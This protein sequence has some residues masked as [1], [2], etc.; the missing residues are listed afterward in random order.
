MSLTEKVIVV[1]GAGSG[2]GRAIALECARASAKVVIADLAEAAARE[3]QSL[4]ASERGA[5][6][7]IAV[8][9]DI[10]QESAVKA[11]FE[12]TRQSFGDIDGVVANAGIIGPKKPAIDL[13]LDEWNS[14][15]AANLTG[16]FLTVIEAARLLVAQGHGG[17]IIATGSS[18]AIRT[19]P[20]LMAYAAS[21]GA[22]HTMMQ[23][24]AVELGPHRI[25]VNTLVPGTTETDATRA[26]P[27]YLEQV[28]GTFPLGEV[29]QPDELG[30]LVAFVLG[31]G[32]KHMT[33]TLLKIDAGRTIA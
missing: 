11:L 14:V 31:D 20:G 2:I 26:L 16:T 8:P 33:G 17:S 18:T 24:L 29:V 1:T 22:V 3:T 25:R 10:R 9:T 27:G 32:L 12:K 5:S 30:R 23:A 4:I 19:V 6:A 21:K 15:M 28:A 13:T 7:V